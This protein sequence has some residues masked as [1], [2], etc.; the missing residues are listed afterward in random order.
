MGSRMVTTGILSGVVLI[1]AMVIAGCG[2]KRAADTATGARAVVPPEYLEADE[3]TDAFVKG[4]ADG[5]A[6]R[7]PR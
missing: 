6:G 2:G 4:Q 5:G 1:N 3:E 7:G